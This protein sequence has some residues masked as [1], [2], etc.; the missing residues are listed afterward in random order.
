MDAEYVLRRL[1][2]AREAPKECRYCGAWIDFSSDIC[3]ECQMT[4][5]EWDEI[6]AERKFDEEG[7]DDGF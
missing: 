6:Q 4:K 5:D 3:E 2:K 1:G 7:N